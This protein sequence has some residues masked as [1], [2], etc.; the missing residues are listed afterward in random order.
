MAKWH[1]HDFDDTQ[2]NPFEKEEKQPSEFELLL[3]Q[4]TST[5]PPRHKKTLSKQAGSQGSSIL[6][7]AFESHL[8]VEAKVT[9]SIKGGFEA[10]IGTKRCFV[11]FSQ[12]DV[13]RI[14]NPDVYVGNSYSFLITE[15]KGQNI[16][17]S[18]K[19]L[20]K[21]EHEAKMAKAKE[22]IAEGQTHKVTIT[23]IVPFGAFVAIESGLEGLIHINEL[24]ESRVK[25]VEDVVQVGDVVSAK[26]IKI[27][28]EPRFR[29]SLSLN[30][31]TDS[32][33]P[34]SHKSESAQ[35]E[36]KGERDHSSHGNAFMAAFDKA[37]KRKK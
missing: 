20:L 5:P 6:Q 15:L 12:M 9:K 23:R 37:N 35:K 11:P 25:K 19:A 4:D 26:I 14:E 29:M 1:H 10:T 7:E 36:N 3:S 31:A 28:H 24:S 27:E 21:D 30:G 16:V 32:A 22:S 17:L 8:P 2:E 13:I 18:R 34:Q 33:S